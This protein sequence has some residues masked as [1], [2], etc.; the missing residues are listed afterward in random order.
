MNK[1]LNIRDEE[2]LLMGLCR[3]S[4]GVELKVMLLALAEGI[5]DWKYFCSLANQHG[6]AALV[7]HNLSKLG[8][9]GLLP[10]NEAASL[11]NA[12]MQNIR[13]NTINMES[14][15]DTLKLMNKNDIKVVLLK[16][17]ALELS[18]YGNEGL[19]QMSDVDVLIE[20]KDCIR[21]WKILKDNGYESL[22]VKSVF[23]KLILA[24]SGKH[25]PSLIKGGFQFEIHHGL[26]GGRKNSLTGMVMDNSTEAGVNGQITYIPSPQVFFLYLIRHLHLHEMKNESQLRLYTDLV[27][28]LEKYRDQIIN[29]NLLSL[30]FEAGM[31]DIL[32]WKL[33]PLRD[34]WGISFP[35]WLN[36]FINRNYTP[37]SIN[38]F[39]FFLK[40]PK[41]NPVTDQS[42]LYRNAVSEIPGL[43]RKLLYIL[44]DLFPTISFMKKR[45]H[46]GWLKALIFYPHRLGKLWLLIR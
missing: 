5:S 10:E 19:R 38:K 3:L 30:A 39:I 46:C 18:V 22:P 17:M 40:S 12:L 13:R 44:G 11:R 21:S 31:S 27:V 16:G 4:F 6:V 36:E 8:F 23:H 26:F 14:L 35:G 1:E 24:D 41:N 42:S 9:I 32:A 29:T 15:A 37:A 43:H 28:L 2:I 33:E 20:K 34:L 45:Y 7:Y 25:L